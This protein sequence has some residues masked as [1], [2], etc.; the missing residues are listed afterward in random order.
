MACVALIECP[1]CGSNISSRAEICPKCG[2][3]VSFDCCTDCGEPMTPGTL[4]CPKCGR[5]N[6]KVPVV[7]GLNNITVKTQFSM[8]RTYGFYT[9]FDAET[10]A[11]KGRVYDS[12][13]ITFAADKPFY[14]RVAGGMTIHRSEIV[15]VY[16]G[17]KYVLRWTKGVLGHMVIEEDP[18]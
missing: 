13:E 1:Q 2:G 12:G 11:V 18:T 8:G 4:T 3:K 5:P 15:K 17:K 14:L 16:P 7:P 9:L 6:D 10:G